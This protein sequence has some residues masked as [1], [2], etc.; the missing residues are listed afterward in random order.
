M[1]TTM[2]LTHAPTL[3]GFLEKA[4]RDVAAREEVQLPDPLDSDINAASDFWQA[5]ARQV[6][7]D[8]RP[9]VTP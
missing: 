1:R 2:D 5:V 9:V 8:A 4:F 6:I 7:W 3:A